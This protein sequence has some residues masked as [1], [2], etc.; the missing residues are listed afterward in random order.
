MTV[1]TLDKAYNPIDL[2]CEWYEK[3]EKSEY[4]SPKGKGKPYCIM[5][6]PPNVTGSLHM[7]HAF[8]QT[9]MDILIRYHRMKGENTLWQVGTDHAGIATQMVVERQLLAQGQS[10]H[11]LGRERFINEI[12]QWKAESGGNITRQLRRIGA[13]VDWSRERFTLDEGL[14]KA[15]QT[16]FIRLYQEG[17]IYR[18]KRLVNWDPI[19]KTAVSDLEV[20]SEEEKG[21]L[22]HI[23]YPLAEGSGHLIVATT[24]PE[25]MLGDVAVA[26]HPADER[27]TALIGKFLK[28]PLT[29]RL[30]PII[31]DDS[32]DPT[33]G[34]GCVKITP[35]HDFNDYAMGERHQ[36]P[37]INIF[38]FDATLNDQV[39]KAYQ[40]LDRLVARTQIVED[41]QKIDLIEKIEDHLLNIP[42]G[43]R[44]GAI[45]EPL[46]TDQWFVKIESL[47]KPAIE[48]VETGKIRFIP[49]NWSKTYFE[50]MRNIQD[51]C[52]SRQVWW[53]HRI[54]AWYDQ[55]GNIYVG[56]NEEKIRAQHSL[57]PELALH[58]D[59]DVLDTWFSSA[60]WPF[61][62]LGWPKQTEELKTFY[63]TQVL[64]TGFDIIFF[65]VARMIMFGLK[66]TD[67][68]PF[69]EVYIHG[70]IQDQDG[71]KMSK[72]KGNVLDP[73][74]LI[75][76]IELE[77]LVKK[78]TQGM[79]QPQMAERIAKLTRTQYPNG[80]QA[81]GTD[82]L[83]FTYAQLAT[84]GRHIRF[85]LNKIEGNR[86]FCNKLWNATRYVLM[87]TEGKLD[88]QGQA[89]KSFTV[90]DK[91]IQS[92][93]QHT[94]KVVAE[95]LDHYRFDLAMQ[96]IYEFTWNEYCDW[97]LELSKPV[98]NASPSV[99]NDRFAQGTRFTLVT[100]LEELLKVIHPFMPY[101]TEALWQR[102]A[103][104][105][106][107]SGDTIMIQAYPVYIESQVNTAVESDI[108][109][110]QAVILGIRNI[111]G[112]MNISPAKP[113]PVYFYNGS[114][115]DKRRLEEHRAL[116]QALAKIDTISWLNLEDKRP[117]AAT[118]LVGNL[119]LLV[120]MA[121]LIDKRAELARLQKELDKLNKDLDKVSK[122]LKN[123][124]FVKNAPKEIV[125]KEK[126]NVRELE[127]K[128][129]KLKER[130]NDIE[131]IE[132]ETFI[133]NEKGR[134][135]EVTVKEHTSSKV[136]KAKKQP[137]DAGTHSK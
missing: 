41:L 27:Y 51:W 3:W 129:N 13:S 111:R 53:G 22:W 132:K 86:H 14:S 89:E 70:L 26:V 90:P 16:V 100:I 21:S 47:A 108:I 55:D 61:S 9:L 106:G 120:P 43:D 4:F 35:A 44:S 80:I 30:I 137:K 11:D 124:H 2:E 84:T 58:Q 131:S 62:T 54:P 24:R 34:T 67:Q 31:A 92:R 29:D 104:L 56:E 77:S 6:P 105:A 110:I 117:T 128:I 49:E 69:H 32:V 65:W 126:N 12:W 5:I 17:L 78:R 87:N 74:D 42:R 115:E 71:Q 18:G 116:L 66:F 118:A 48:A 45:L 68:I 102:V 133:G 75:D 96:A 135:I 28:L 134:S 93:W 121:G 122:Q 130:K 40:G 123:E 63:P 19:L 88:N 59:E 82:A 57:P 15:V 79:M 125:D 136:E 20:E 46:L 94:K 85:D 76:G 38:T 33:F 60:L 8:Q 50:W 97:Y 127:M 91:W 95:H 103:P 52:I 72:T 1:S 113:I 107:K 101:I 109:W 10:R 98:L 112:E 81:Y 39:P 114:T 83:R 36:L 64:V 23:R 25:T 99:E 119:E 73:I 7:G 37:K